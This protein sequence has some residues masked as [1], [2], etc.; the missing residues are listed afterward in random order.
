MGRDFPAD[1]LVVMAFVT[2][3]PLE[4]HRSFSELFFE[5]L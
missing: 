2:G 1:V 4:Q 5:T 3:W